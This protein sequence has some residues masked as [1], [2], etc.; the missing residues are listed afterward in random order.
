MLGAAGTVAGHVVDAKGRPVA[1]AIV[2]AGG[3]G[4]GE[5]RV[6][7][8]ATGAFRLE[9]LYEGAV[10][11]TAQTIDGIGGASLQVGVQDATIRLAAWPREGRLEVPA[12]LNSCSDPEA[13]R[14]IAAE[15]LDEFMDRYAEGMKEYQLREWVCA[16]ALLDPA[17]AME[18]SARN[19]SR[20]DGDVCQT[21]A[22]AAVRR[23]P[24]EVMGYI[25]GVAR[26]RVWTLITA[27]RRARADRPELSLSLAQRAVSEGR[28]I[29]SPCERVIYTAIAAEA[30]Y[31]VDPSAAVPV[32]RDVAG[33]ARKLGHT[34][35]DEYARGCAAETLCRVDLPG[36]LALLD[37]ILG[38]KE[39]TRHQPNV[40]AR[41]AATSPERVPELLAGAEQWA[42]GA[43]LA[44]VVYAM[45]PAAP[46]QA[47]ELARAAEQSCT[48]VRA[49]AYAALALSA[50]DPVRALRV[51]QEAV[52]IVATAASGAQGPHDSGTFR[53]R[54]LQPIGGELVW[55]GAQMGYPN[56][57]S[58]AWLA[59][60]LRPGESADRR[61]PSGEELSYLRGLALA[62]PRL[63]ADLIADMTRQPGAL[64][65]DT[66]SRKLA[67]LILSAAVAD[68]N[69]AA[70]LLRATDAKAEGDRRTVDTGLWLDSINLLLADPDERPVELLARF[71][72]WVPG[73]L[74]VD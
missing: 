54:E 20:F 40:A 68:A 23:A 6:Q 32:I 38:E 15:L 25:D 72:D 12:S 49:L 35:R 30:L 57:D 60:A 8:D 29:E 27:A 21:L 43:K 70:H 41:I 7:A 22:I 56:V 14:R 13:D 28:A 44:R 63:A 59:L 24:E 52:D 62:R 4:P 26:G 58:L 39:G 11:V 18:L 33:I 47:L 61:G 64:E 71:G 48:R 66:Y 53:A 45:A 67:H 73:A 65:G 17:K 31:E 1:G 36:A 19:G 34:E 16:W 2:R 50:Q 10:W 46:D 74:N 9:G 69:L 37:E 51:M 3:E 5:L 55:V 42:R